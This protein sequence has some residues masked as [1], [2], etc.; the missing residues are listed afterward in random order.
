MR[1]QPTAIELLEAVNEFLRAEAIPALADRAAFHTRVAANVLDIVRRELKLGPAAEQ[2]ETERLRALLGHDGER[3][4]LNAELCDLIAE[5]GIE[6]TDSR[7]IEHLWAT[8][9]D[10]L[11]VDQ[12]N[13][14]TYRRAAE[15][16]RISGR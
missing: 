6:L 13:Y 9:L 5:G 4:A 1:E 10:T 15:T 7:L 12:P 2:S 14:A 3:E 16:S 8:T 11:S